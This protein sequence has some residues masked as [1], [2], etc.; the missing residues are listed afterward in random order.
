MKK[1]DNQK[2]KCNVHNCEHCNCECDVCKLDKIDV[3]TCNCD[4]CTSKEETMCASFKN[5]K[6]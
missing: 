1:E 2:I 3:C 4:D 5:K 6:D